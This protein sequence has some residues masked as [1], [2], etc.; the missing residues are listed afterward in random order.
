MDN[1]SQ[2][3]LLSSLTPLTNTK[4][5]TPIFFTFWMFKFSKPCVYLCQWYRV[6]PIFS[7]EGTVADHKHLH[8]IRGWGNGSGRY[9]SYLQPCIRN[10]RLVP[11][12]NQYIKQGQKDEGRTN[13]CPSCP[14]DVESVHQI[15]NLG[16]YFKQMKVSRYGRTS[17]ASIQAQVVRGCSHITNFSWVL[18]LQIAM[19][20]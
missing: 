6:S 11:S 10:P 5:V 20:E 14:L 8:R 16:I 3:A 15:S 9:S 18:A 19:V 17:T 13:P 12:A 1:L 2:T 4:N 7:K